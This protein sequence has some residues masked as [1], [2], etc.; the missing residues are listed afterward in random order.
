MRSA[1]PAPAS[2]PVLHRRPL[3]AVALLVA[4]LVS[5]ACAGAPTGSGAG[6]TSPPGGPRVLAA[7][8]FLADIAQNVAGDR[9]KIGALVPE[10]VDPHAFEPTPAD[11][12]RVSE[13]GMI[14]INGAGFE[15]FLGTILK[16][17]RSD[18]K[19]VEASAGLQTQKASDEGGHGEEDPHFWLDPTRTQRYVENI[20]D[21][22]SGVDPG[23]AEAFRAN[24]ARY[25]AELVELDRWIAEQVETVPAERRV[26]VTNH[27]SFGYFADRYGFRI[28][29]TILRSVSTGASPSA[30]DLARLI[31]SIRASGTRAIFLETGTNPQL[32]APDRSRNRRSS[33]NRPAHPLHIPRRADVHRNDASRRW[34][35]SGGAP[36]NRGLARKRNNA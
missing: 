21:A 23:G 26:L 2:E 12:A 4:A 18:L 3:V 19:V 13:A 24:G 17:A 16:Q 11:V 31:D 8:T 27:E 6:A 34:E 35:D 36:V 32:A 20:R 1:R 14:I 28:A 22:L 29:G 15:A 33:D 10:G 5:A 30:Q 25:S 7:E 9:I